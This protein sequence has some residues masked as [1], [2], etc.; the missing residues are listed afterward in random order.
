M[1]LTYEYMIVSNYRS[2]MML[3]AFQILPW[4]LQEVMKSLYNQYQNFLSL[5]IAVCILYSALKFLV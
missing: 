4:V 3:Y 1:L 5:I 2:L